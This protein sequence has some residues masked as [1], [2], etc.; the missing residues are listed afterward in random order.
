MPSA[1]GR[2]PQPERVA[3]YL[4]VSSEEQRE[5]ETIEIQDKFLDEYCRLY[6]LEMAEVYADDGVS[7]TVPLHERPAGRRLLEDAKAGKFDA[8]LVYKLDRLG[9]KLLVI[10]DAHDRLAEAGVS[11]RSAREPIDTS[12]PSG[13]LIFQMLASFAEYD[14]DNIAERTRAGL[15][16]A[17]RAG[18][19]MGRVPY[20]YKT[21]EDSR[22]QVVPEEAEV[23]RAIFRNVAD[24]STLYAEA[25][26]LNDLGVAG[27][28]HRYGSREGVP[29]WRWTNTT[30]S[31][32][33]R[34]RAYSGTHEV[35][36][37]GDAIEREVPAIV[38]PELQERARAALRENKRRPNREGNRRY[39][40]GG[41]V[42]CETCGY[43]CSGHATWGK[44]KRYSYYSCIT[45]KPLGRRSRPLAPRPI[46][47]R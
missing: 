29:G 20:G 23:V 44:G 2:G 32:I 42:R 16:R 22:L 25:K 8:V 26:R 7:G 11:L 17:F 37:G 10:V 35:R 12:N 21:D 39:L 45:N 28:G 30:I 14:R 46:R 15:H 18:K 41:L 36:I 38:S 40:L 24:G 27:A 34:Q 19:Y 1:S 13:R 5:R 6:G 33:V 4:R 31:G 3:S 9:R 47:A 43:G